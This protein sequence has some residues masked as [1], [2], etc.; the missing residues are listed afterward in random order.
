MIFFLILLLESCSQGKL[1]IGYLYHESISKYFSLEK[2]I[3]TALK[4]NKNHYTYNITP[5][6]IYESSGISHIE[7]INTNLENGNF[8]IIIFTPFLIQEMSDIIGKYPDILF[9]THGETDYLLLNNFPNMYF[10]IPDYKKLGQIFAGMIN[11]NRHKKINQKKETSQNMIQ[12]DVV[13]FTQD[14]KEKDIFIEEMKSGLKGVN[15]HTFLRSKYTPA[16][17]IKSEANKYLDKGIKTFVILDM[18]DRNIYY[19]LSNTDYTVFEYYD[20][21]SQQN[22]IQKK[23]WVKT[24]W[25]KAILSSIRELVLIG[26]QLDSDKKNKTKKPLEI[27]DSEDNEKINKQIRIPLK[28]VH[29]DENEVYI[30]ENIQKNNKLTHSITVNNETNNNRNQHNLV[31]TDEN[32]CFVLSDI[33]RQEI[34]MPDLNIFDT[35]IKPSVKIPDSSETN[36][37]NKNF[38]NSAFKNLAD[39][40]E[41]LRFGT[42][43]HIFT[44]ENLVFLNFELLNPDLTKS[45]LQQFKHITISSSQ[46]NPVYS[47]EKCT[48]VLDKPRKTYKFQFESDDKN[49]RLFLNSSISVYSDENSTYLMTEYLTNSQLKSITEQ[50][51][52][53]TLKSTDI[54]PLFS[55][56]KNIIVLNNDDIKLP[57]TYYEIYNQVCNYNQFLVFNNENTVYVVA[58]FHTVE[59]LNEF[60]SRY[61]NITFKAP[62]KR[63]LYTDENNI[64]IV[65]KINEQFMP[66]TNKII[67]SEK[68]DRNI[69]HIPNNHYTFKYVKPENKTTDKISGDPNSVE[70]EWYGYPIE[71]KLFTV[72]KEFFAELIEDTKRIFQIPVNGE[73]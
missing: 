18:M 24:D 44:D 23:A 30:T 10:I 27:N 54:K 31:Y 15:I 71:K 8:N 1:Q 57:D 65:D 32:E 37:I 35:G 20:F 28:N 55:D 29:I 51:H 7:Q 70:D 19:N 67:P 41:S 72:I 11:D 68:K 38:I 17:Q 64:Y 48:Y 13:I 33:S 52:F 34:R 59:K 42:K 61:N 53:I 9:S 62:G 50:A 47:D 56:E 4:K 39:S 43:A 36:I 12:N 40:S 21:P 66:E 14:S 16:S 3:L 2:D 26:R 73:N 46:L 63:L 22:Q 6:R 5:I 60:I 45:Y 25:Q 49:N 58:S 69:I